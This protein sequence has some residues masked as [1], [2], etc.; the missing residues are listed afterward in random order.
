MP[1]AAALV[2]SFAWRQGIPVA[3]IAVSWLTCLALCLGYFTPI[4]AVITF[5][6]QGALL[7]VRLLSIEAGGVLLLDT[8]ALTLLGAGAYSLDARRFGRRVLDV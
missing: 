3:A 1:V 7:C 8:L 2:L 4:A 5:L 6:L